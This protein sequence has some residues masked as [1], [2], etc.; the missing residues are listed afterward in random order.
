LFHQFLIVLIDNKDVKRP[1][2]Y[3]DNDPTIF[4]GAPE[5]LD[6]IDNDC[7]GLVDEGL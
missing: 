4:P 3:C 6:G 1:C 7:D 5:V 2:N